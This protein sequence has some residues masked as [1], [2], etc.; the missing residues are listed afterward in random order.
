L[1]TFLVRNGIPGGRAFLF[2]GTF[3]RHSGAEREML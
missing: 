2:F 1:G 3:G